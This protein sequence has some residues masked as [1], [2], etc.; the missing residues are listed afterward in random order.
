MGFQNAP[1]GAS[2]ST[3]NWDLDMTVPAA[4]KIKTDHIAE[5]TA[6]HTVVMDSSVLLATTKTIDSTDTTGSVGS[7][8]MSQLFSMLGGIL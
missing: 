2:V 4:Y 6:G 5:T 7:N 1:G 3:L 8:L